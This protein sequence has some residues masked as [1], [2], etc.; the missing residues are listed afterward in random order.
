[1]IIWDLRKGCVVAVTL[2]EGDS[3]NY[4]VP[5]RNGDQV[6]NYLIN[7]SNT[8]HHNHNPTGFLKSVFVILNA[9]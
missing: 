7:H 2:S 5:L 9:I 1:M 6:A 8:D 3:V 4:I